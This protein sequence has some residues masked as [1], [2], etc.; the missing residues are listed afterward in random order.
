ME[1]EAL[2]LQ[3]SVRE[4]YQILL[5]A[6]ARMPLPIAY[7]KIAA[8]YRTLAQKCMAWAIDVQGELLRR[9]FSELESVR[10][11]SRFRMRLYSLEMTV[12]WEDGTHAAILCESRFTGDERDGYHRLSHVWDLR[13]ETV[14]PLSQVEN[15]FLVGRRREK[16]PFSPDGIYPEGDELIYFKNPRSASPFSEMRIPIPSKTD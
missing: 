5:R 8:Y 16:L 15:L 9:T 7:P 10:E 14:L 3:E 1:T 2:Q 4:G 13:E 11:K 12:P 6:D